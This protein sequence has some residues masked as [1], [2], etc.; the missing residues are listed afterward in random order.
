MDLEFQTILYDG[1]AFLES[2]LPAIPKSTAVYRIFD[3][4]DQLIVLNK[5][6]NLSHRLERFFG[7]HSERVRDLDLRQ[8]TSRIEFVRTFSPFE[9]AYALYLERRKHFPGTYRRMKT[10]RY[11]TLLKINRKQRFPLVYASRQIKAGVDYFGPFTTRGQFARMKTALERT[12]KLRPCQ[13]NIR[14]NDPHPDCL[15]FQMH[16]CSRPCNGDIDRAGYLEDVLRAMAFLQGRDDAIRQPWVEEMTRLAADMKF[17]EAET[18]KKKVE[19]LQRA[20]QEQQ[21]L[22]DAFSDLQ[23]F[24]FVIVLPS[25]TSSQVKIVIVRGGAIVAFRTHET[26]TLRETLQSELSHSFDSNL[27]APNREWLYDEFCLVCTFMVKS[28]QSVQ[29]IRYEGN[30]E[31]TAVAIEKR[32]KRTNARRPPSIRSE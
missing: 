19:R 3:L 21:S 31:D 26:A 20:R 14:G 4:H 18:I 29:F 7:P 28:L 16:T 15:Y 30:A 10:F 11:F 22:K 6:S 5:T 25:D 23:S 1:S 2:A 27:P 24:N 8:I 32:M 17:E 9:T 12:F 13:F